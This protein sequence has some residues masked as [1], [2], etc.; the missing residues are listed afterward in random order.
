MRGLEGV[1]GG[2]L[3]GGGRAG[4]GGESLEY[5]GIGRGGAGGEILPEDRQG[6]ARATQP[7]AAAPEARHHRR[8]H[9]TEP[10]RRDG[11]GRDQSHVEGHT[12]DAARSGHD[13]ERALQRVR[14][15]REGLAGGRGPGPASKAHKHV[16]GVGAEAAAVQGHD[17]GPGANRGPGGTLER[18]AGD[19]GDL[20]GGVL[21]RDGERDGGEATH[22]DGQVPDLQQ[23]QRCGQAAHKGRAGRALGGAAC[24]VARGAAAGPSE[25]HGVVAGVG[26]VEVAALDRQ[27]V[28]ALAGPSAPPDQVDLRRRGRGYFHREVEHGVPVEHV[29]CEVEKAGNAGWHPQLT[30][31]GTGRGGHHDALRV[32]GARCA[33][34]RGREDDGRGIVGETTAGERQE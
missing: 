12:P 1:H 6:V 10:H 4:G 34:A 20:G 32:C 9:R 19:G 28:P 13:G 3:A 22:G 17:V 21:Q 30:R 23:D 24:W 31:Q 33:K 8:E 16:R 7:Q 2:D 29:H 14:R 11:L 5:E 18:A 25:G 27:E 26:G 15:G